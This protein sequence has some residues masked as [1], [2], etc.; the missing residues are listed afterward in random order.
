MAVTS[1]LRHSPALVGLL[2]A[3]F[4]RAGENVGHTDDSVLAIFEGFT[5]SPPHLLNLIDPRWTS[6]GIAVVVA[7]DE[8]WVTMEF[9]TTV[10]CSATASA[11]A[12]TVASAPTSTAARRSHLNKLTAAERRVSAR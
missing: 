8:L 11:P 7:G 6:V 5:A 12:S 1:A 10:A 9:G 3:G 2:D 4:N